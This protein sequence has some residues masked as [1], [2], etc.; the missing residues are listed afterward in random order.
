[1]RNA[2]R[3]VAVCHTHFDRVAIAQACHKYG[4]AAQNFSRLD[5]ARVARRTWIDCAW[6]GYGLS[7]VSKMLGFEFKHH[8]AL[9]DAK[10]SAHILIKACEVKALDIEGWLSR[11]RGP[12]IPSVGS[13][14]EAITRVENPEG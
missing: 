6:K 10:A 13:T 14:S 3:K 5:S 2:R 8:D 4:I 12:I 7:P 11:V 1:M 9:E